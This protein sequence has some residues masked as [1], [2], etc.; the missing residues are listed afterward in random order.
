M[1]EVTMSADSKRGSSEVFLQP[2]A[3]WPTDQERVCGNDWIRAAQGSD[4]G[5][6][7]GSSVGDVEGLLLGFHRSVCVN[8]VSSCLKRS[9]HA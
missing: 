3:S 7:V 5:G 6:G 9:R 4:V 1:R 2:L 8:L